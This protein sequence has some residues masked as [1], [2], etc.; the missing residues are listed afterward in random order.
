M[1]GIYI[2]FCGNTENIP[3]KAPLLANFEIKN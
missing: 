1:H 3:N 2:K